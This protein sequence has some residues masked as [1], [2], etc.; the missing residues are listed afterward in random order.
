MKKF[1]YFVQLSVC[2]IWS[3]V[4]GFITE[5]EGEQSLIKDTVLGLYVF[6]SRAVSLATK[7]KPLRPCLLNSVG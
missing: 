1:L 4:S 6:R 5:Y 7:Q 3:C 2:D